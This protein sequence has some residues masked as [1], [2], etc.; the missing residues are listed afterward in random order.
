MDHI[1]FSNQ[2]LKSFRNIFLASVHPRNFGKP[3]NFKPCNFN[4]TDMF[5]AFSSIFY[6]SPAN[7]LKSAVGYTELYFYS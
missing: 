6:S 7:I 4:T 5:M 1:L 3:Y 2:T